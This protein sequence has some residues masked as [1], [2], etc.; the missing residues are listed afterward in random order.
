MKLFRALVGSPL[1]CQALRQAGTPR[2]EIGTPLYALETTRQPAAEHAN[3]LFGISGAY[4]YGRFG[5][6]SNL[7]K[8]ILAMQNNKWGPA[9]LKRYKY[10]TKLL[11]GLREGLYVDTKTTLVKHAC[12]EGDHCGIRL[13]YR[14]G[15]WHVMTFLLGKGHSETIQ[16]RGAF[17]FEYVVGGPCEVT[18]RSLT[19]KWVSDALFKTY[20]R[21]R[22]FL[23]ARG[24][25]ERDL[26]AVNSTWVG[27]LA[28]S[29]NRLPADLPPLSDGYA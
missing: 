4:P 26:V 10:G 9:A 19:L 14:I 18:I 12:Y 27:L 16:R 6:L 17:D 24:S 5:T 23:V 8:S 15:K 22:F 1:G 13:A 25:V 2:F 29:K 28:I 3:A 11:V 7:E 21:A 20:H